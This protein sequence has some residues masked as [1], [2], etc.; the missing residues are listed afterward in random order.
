[1]YSLL[2]PVLLTTAGLAAS[3][4]L[5]PLG[6]ER[7]VLGEEFAKRQS[8][9]GCLG[10]AAPS[11]SANKT[12]VW[13]PITPED[14]LAVWNLLHANESGLNLTDPATANLTDNYVFWIDTVHTNKSDVL[15]YLDG[16]GPMPAKYARAVIFEGGKDEPGS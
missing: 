8:H 6:Y 1:M 9:G 3:S 7:S 15:P 16:D 14:N 5:P 11:T 12:N 2:L 10:G 4:A 13:A